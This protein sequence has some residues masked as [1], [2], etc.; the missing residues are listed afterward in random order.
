MNSRHVARALYILLL[1]TLGMLPTVSAAAVAGDHQVVDGVAIYLGLIPSEMILR[2]PQG[3]PEREM[4][5]GVPAGKHW[6]H[7]V[8]ALF[9][10]NGKR[11]TDAQVTA[12]VREIGLAGE[13]K[14]L[15]PMKIAGTITYG[16]YFD[17]PTRDT[18]YRILIRIRFPGV[19]GTIKADFTQHH[20]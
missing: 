12:T 17:F 6:D 10:A 19:P 2:H 9:D 13:T 1:I 18:Y 20:Y 3:H 7:L 14:E 16:N 8:V 4:H 5:G 11:I 15:Q